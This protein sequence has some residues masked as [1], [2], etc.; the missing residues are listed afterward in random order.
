MLNESSPLLTVDQNVRA[1]KALESSSPL[2]PLPPEVQLDLAGTTS[3]SPGG[4]KQ[5]FTGLIDDFAQAEAE[6]SPYQPPEIWTPLGSEYS[7]GQEVGRLIYGMTGAGRVET[8]SDTS[9]Q[10]WKQRAV[11][12]GLLN[13]SP[14]EIQDP[15]WYPEYS[16]VAA[17]MLREQSRA[18][19]SGDK[20]G[21]MSV[22]GVMNL[23]EEWLSPR[24]LYQAALE[25]DLWW[26]FNAI[27]R[28]KEEWGDKWRAWGEE[29]WNP[30][31]AID[32]LTGPT[33][34][35][36]F[37]VINWALMF[38]GVG[39]VYNTVRFG[40]KGV[41]VGTKAVTGAHT[42]AG[43]RSGSKGVRAMAA[44]RKPFVAADRAD[45]IAFF[46]NQSFM[47]NLL[48]PGTQGTQTG[49]V[50]AGLDSLRRKPLV[51]G[52]A[53][54][55]EAWR[56]KTGVVVAKKANQQVLRLGISSNLQGL[57]DDSRGHSLAST[58]TI[59]DA[60]EAVMSNPIADWGVD[61]FLY[62]PNIFE[63][64]TLRAAAAG[65]GRLGR[66]V[67]GYQPVKENQKMVMSWHNGIRNWLDASGG[68]VAAFD[69]T[70]NEKGVFGAIADT[71]ANGDEELAQEVMKFVTVST[72][73]DWS[74]RTMGGYSPVAVGGVMSAD[75]LS[76]FNRARN[77]LIAQLRYY[78]PD[79]PEE[80]INAMARYGLNLEEV[81]QGMIPKDTTIEEIAENQRRM[82]D[83]W[84]EPAEDV[85][86]RA[87]DVADGDVRLYGH[88]DIE[89]GEVRWT[90]DEP[91]GLAD[92]GGDLAQLTFV[93]DPYFADVNLD[94][95]G[96]TA[97]QVA[98]NP[99]EFGELVQ[100]RYRD[101]LGRR[102]KVSSRLE[103]RRFDQ[104]KLGDL[105][106]MI[107]QHNER[108]AKTLAA[109]LSNA[110]EEMVSQGVFEAM[111][112]FGRWSSWS[113]GMDEVAR[114]V[115]SGDLAN[116]P[117]KQVLTPTGAR[118][119]V[120]P[121]FASGSGD[122]RWF[123]EMHRLLNSL[124]NDPEQRRR[125]MESVFAPLVREMDP[126]AQTLTLA[127]YSADAAEDTATKQEALAF[128]HTVNTHV[129]RVEDARSVMNS[130]PNLFGQIDEAIDTARLADADP[131]EV[132]DTIRNVVAELLSGQTDKNQRRIRRLV[133]Y[134]V[135]NNVSMADISKKLNDDTL[136]LISRQDVW[137]RYRVAEQVG[138][139]SQTPLENLSAKLKE[140]KGQ[141]NYIA[142]EVDVPESLATFLAD[143]GY[144]LVYGVNFLSPDD[145]A[146]IVPK[147]DDLT[148][149]HIRSTR[150]QS[151]FGRKDP[152][153]VLA[154]KNKVVKSSLIAS[155]HRA[156]ARG[157]DI[158]NLNLE[159][160]ASVNRLISQLYEV[161]D[162]AQETAQRTIESGGGMIAR[163]G[164][165]ISVSLVPFDLS[166]LPSG[167]SRKQFLA[168][169]DRLGYT[170]DEAVAIQEAL[171]RSQSLGFKEQGLYAIES[172]LRSRNNVAEG[173]RLL[174]RHR[175]LN[176]LE[177]TAWHGLGTAGAITGAGLV[178]VEDG[179][180]DPTNPMNYI[181]AAAGAALGAGSVHMLGR[182][183]GRLSQMDNVGKFA[184]LA[185]KVEG[186]Q[187]S[188]YG[189]LADNL[190][191]IRDRFRFSLSP[192]FDAS[193]YS[194]AIILSQ[195][196]EIPPGLRNL[197]MN[198]SPSGVR[199]A[200]RRQIKAM[201][202]D[203]SPTQL[204]DMSA[205]L[206]G[207]N[208][209][210]FA[211][212][213]RH[214]FEME[215]IDD[216]GRRFS[217]VG[218]LGFSPVNWMEATFWHLRQSGVGKRK[219]YETVRD[220]YT[221]GVTGRSSAELSMNFVFFPF[222]F[223][224]KMVGHLAKFAQQDM[225]R[226]IL[227]QDALATYQLLNEHY[228]LSDEWRDRL[229][230]LNR[231]SRLNVLAYGIGPGRFGGVNAP[232]IG[233]A[234]DTPVVGDL[235][236]GPEIDEI[237]NLFVPNMVT[238]NRA[239]DANELWKN[240]KQ[241]LPAM[242]DVN[243]MV[244]DLISQGHV[245]TSDSHLTK[246]AEARRGW[247]EWREYQKSLEPVMEQTG[248]T[249]QSLMTE[250]EFNAMVTAKRADIGI[251]FPEWKHAVGDGIAHSSAI[252]I[253]IQE[254]L[255]L[256]ATGQADPN[257]GDV[258]LVAFE[259]DM[260]SIQDAL[261][262]VGLSMNN[263]EDVPPEVY[264]IMRRR[265][266]ELAMQNPRFKRLYD[267]FY[268]RLFGDI[269]T[270]LT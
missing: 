65:A 214:D 179:D 69:K 32:A 64:G 61:L 186:S 4:L 147:F 155:L 95:F 218:V 123:D 112:S 145:L 97:A 42:V 242:N 258:Q 201:N 50:A 176:R 2:P 36:V 259:K 9:V 76:R 177:N 88:R 110:N 261:S 125:L 148:R 30:A 14:S 75:E 241:A 146:G 215:T 199:R 169:M 118:A 77:H 213:A 114:M 231:M 235:Y 85:Q 1:I 159:D 13:L 221:Y 80:A 197:R 48:R 188:K 115:D 212:A 73:I 31:R 193:R 132:R 44:I 170:V 113:E 243:Q 192:I 234:R 15:R 3:L 260:R 67:T 100:R 136:D 116:V 175:A 35:L 236:V 57:V 189:Y 90:T 183:T 38:V 217:S 172:T 28:E 21:S 117:L 195:I 245:L 120:N 139:D 59:D 162:E 253:E 10:D 109:M 29:L 150:L 105:K 269:S 126:T 153:I 138:M 91:M 20:P 49:A 173:L 211:H 181:E 220:I 58:T 17:E 268:R 96:V 227:A 209:D 74:A 233:A 63:R 226:L 151:W 251:A 79:K 247:E 239:D 56:T 267:R 34:D 25:L 178:A 216:V 72:A 229:P 184:E 156:K 149:R 266:T 41:Q 82:R 99:Q 263:P 102:Q 122:R 204:D 152:D 167:M 200:I 165:R 37:P 47:A 237:T 265:A 78:D 33:D 70:V 131:K 101:A 254:R 43:I 255:R 256:A 83:S 93:E 111:E 168:K 6:P 144:K 194:E 94:E 244:G 129:R 108:R 60:V 240:L 196:G 39:E 223:T 127:R 262:L 140:L 257:S 174:G 18:E 55:M 248:R 92:E 250:P 157:D 40:V 103:V 81:P 202:P 137:G 68:D 158:R 187:F 24:G 198:Q 207:R 252:D 134:A 185:S 26:D 124:G 8:Y 51:S 222:S 182:A 45:D 246:M 160:N 171:Y 163:T 203:M 161:L 16:S 23:V 62:P 27:G 135:E 53:G 219:A 98:D 228:D 22:D 264:P 66:A 224:K 143:R 210:E 206:W 119:S 71:V 54:A 12:M 191:N 89:T 106:M 270:E 232:M 121:P 230:V 130:S 205:S 225:G 52:A 7:R 19:F 133:N 5:L 86:A 104:S 128:V 190:A 84:L 11:D 180:F 166:R 208:R 141:A 238:M 249:W 87:G 164:Q 107:N 46:K 154:Q 142:A